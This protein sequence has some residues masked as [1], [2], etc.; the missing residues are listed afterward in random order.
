[1][2]KSITLRLDNEV[3]KKLHIDKIKLGV[4]NRCSYN[5]EEYFIYLYRNK[6]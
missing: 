2:V 1:M 6:K 3:F 5:W 4:K